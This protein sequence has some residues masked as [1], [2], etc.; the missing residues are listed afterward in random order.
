M[1]SGRIFDSIDCLIFTCSREL[2][3]ELALE[4]RGGGHWDN[5]RDYWFWVHED[6]TREDREQIAGIVKKRKTK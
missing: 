2:R 5:C 1:N 6:L 3:T 4:P